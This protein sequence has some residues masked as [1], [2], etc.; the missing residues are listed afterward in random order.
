V[1][2]LD[3]ERFFEFLASQFDNPG[4]V[5]LMPDHDC[6]SIAGVR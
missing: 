5:P 6:S 3:A 1:L 4:G 2:Q